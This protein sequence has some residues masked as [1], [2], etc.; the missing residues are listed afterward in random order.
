MQ[1]NLNGQHLAKKIKIA[2][3]S[4]SI[5]LGNSKNNTREQVT[6]KQAKSGAIKKTPSRLD[7]RV[8]E[9]NKKETR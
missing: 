9:I 2:K 4:L 5:T 1:L 6:K 3:F 8:D 7:K